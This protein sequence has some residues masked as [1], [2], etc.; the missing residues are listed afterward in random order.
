MSV[1]PF[2]FLKISIPF[3]NPALSLSLSLSLSS[4]LFFLL[5]NR[6]DYKSPSFNLAA[7]IAQVTL[8]PIPSVRFCNIIFLLKI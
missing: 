5:P 2:Y 6:Q 8:S 3:H 1:D 7:R 4:L